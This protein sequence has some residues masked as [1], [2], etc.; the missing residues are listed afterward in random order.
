[1]VAYI[2]YTHPI[3]YKLKDL[4]GKAIIGTFYEQEMQKSN[5]NTFRI[6]KLWRTIGE[7]IVEKWIGYSDDY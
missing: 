7:K 4:N 2:H 5:Q 1:V 6:E 3:T